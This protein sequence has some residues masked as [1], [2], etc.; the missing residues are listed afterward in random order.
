MCSLLCKHAI[1]LT[2]KIITET[3]DICDDKK[4]V[5]CTPIYTPYRLDFGDV[6]AAQKLVSQV[7]YTTP[8]VEFSQSARR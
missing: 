2:F 7:P 8:Y 1:C 3:H 5:V 4:L 6:V